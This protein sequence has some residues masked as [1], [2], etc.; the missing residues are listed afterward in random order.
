MVTDI[1]RLE[2][3]LLPDY[4]LPAHPPPHKHTKTHT[5]Q[6]KGHCLPNDLCPS[7]PPAHTTIFP[8]LIT[9]NAPVFL[10]HNYPK[11]RE[12]LFHKSWKFTWTDFNCTYV[13]HVQEIETSLSHNMNELAPRALWFL[14]LLVRKLLL[15]KFLN[16]WFHFCS[17][18]LGYLLFSGEQILWHRLMRCNELFFKTNNRFLFC[19]ICI[20]NKVSTED[21]DVLKK[22]KITLLAK[23]GCCMFILRL[24]NLKVK[25]SKCM[26]RH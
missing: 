21:E 20:M 18:C 7:Y 10:S 13:Q 14:I 11:I 9:T 24:V 26:W 8:I 3:Y 12:N 1:L 2:Q 15:L 22:D 6:Q 17:C 19:L 16:R 5:H 23:V 25:K 4:A